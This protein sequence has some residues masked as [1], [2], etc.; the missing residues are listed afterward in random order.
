MIIDLRRARLYNSDL[1]GANLVGA[2]LV[3]ADFEGR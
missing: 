3:E 2:L 1:V